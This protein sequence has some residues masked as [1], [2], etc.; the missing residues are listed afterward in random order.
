MAHAV[1]N[2]QDKGRGTTSLAPFGHG[3]GGGGPTRE[4]MERARRLASLEG[5]A[6]VRVEHP[7]AFFATAREEIPGTRSGPVSCTWSCTT[8]PTPAGPHQA[9]QPA[10]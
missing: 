9:G 2:Y 1:R 3:D 8:P 7:D 4:M 6:K 10:Q 5:S